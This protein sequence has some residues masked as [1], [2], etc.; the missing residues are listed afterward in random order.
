MNILFNILAVSP[1]YRVTI[2][3]EVAQVLRLCFQPMLAQNICRL[4]SR[5]YRAHYSFLRPEIRLFFSSFYCNAY[6]SA[7]SCQGS[8]IAVSSWLFTAQSMRET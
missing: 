5:E 1:T 3:K 6:Q 8:A 2:P 7:S 4:E